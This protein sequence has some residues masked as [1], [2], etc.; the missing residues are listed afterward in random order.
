M[1]TEA[2]SLFRKKF[3]LDQLTI[4]SNNNWNLSVRPGQMT[5]GSMVVSS[6]RGK[7]NFTDLDS[8]DGA[9]LTSILAMAENTVLKLYG[10]VRINV[11]CLM[12]QDPIIH[13]HIIPRYNKPIMLYGTEWNDIDW[14]GPPVF[15]AVATTDKILMSVKNDILGFLG[16]SK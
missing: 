14:P 6:V 2:L 13:F 16:I 9:S 7:Q 10:G 15:K 8:Q 1:E 11:I 12:M 3:N 5:L 4:Q